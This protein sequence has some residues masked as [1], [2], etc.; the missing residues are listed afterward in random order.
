MGYEQHRAQK[1]HFWI[2]MILMIVAVIL[3]PIGLD[4]LGDSLSSDEEHM[5]IYESLGILS[6]ILLCV[7]ILIIF[8]IVNT[9]STYKFRHGWPKDYWS[10]WGILKKVAGLICIIICV[11]LFSVTLSNV[12]GD[13]NDEPIYN[14]IIIS[15]EAPRVINNRVSLYYY[16]EGDVEKENIKYKHNLY[17]KSGVS[18]SAG[19]TYKIRVYERSDFWVAVEEIVG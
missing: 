19:K 11:V 18:V 15:D 14:T 13:L 16:E 5:Y 17:V 8:Y 9:I 10:K 12:M 2:F 6:I 3:V 7:I 1:K 4:M